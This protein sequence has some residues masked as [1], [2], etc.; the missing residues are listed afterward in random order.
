[1]NDQLIA[2]LSFATLASAVTWF[3]VSRYYHRRLDKR[4]NRTE[5]VM[6]TQRQDH[7]RELAVR[8]AVTRRLER[9]NRQLREELRSALL[10][11]GSCTQ[12]GPQS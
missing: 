10:A 5:R 1:V 4:D 2:L 12:R 11:C 7:G 3:L 8:D 6:D 9:D